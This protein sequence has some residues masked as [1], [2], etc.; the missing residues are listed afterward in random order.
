[1]PRSNH[2]LHR[3]RRP[4][5]STS[6]SVPGPPPDLLAPGEQA[7]L[8]RA[9]LRPNAAAPRP[10]ITQA[11]EWARTVRLQALILD[12]VLEGGVDI[13]VSQDGSDLVFRAHAADNVIPLSAQRGRR[14]RP[15]A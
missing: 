6:P 10:T 15:I 13:L 2:T 9:V 3:D 11:L 7:A 5:R 4:V 12:K 1:M 14:G 8:T